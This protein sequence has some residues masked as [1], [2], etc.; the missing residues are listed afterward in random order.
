MKTC[1]LIVFLM[2]S[3]IPLT[4]LG[5]SAYFKALALQTAGPAMGEQIISGLLIQ[6]LFIT[7][8]GVVLSVTLSLVVSKSVSAPLEEMETAMKEVA[9]GN[10]DVHIRV[11]SNDAGQS[12][13]GSAG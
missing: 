9:K 6:I 2:I 3:L 4:L 11:V 7:A 5:F 1:L 10:L 8:M 13:R 12:A